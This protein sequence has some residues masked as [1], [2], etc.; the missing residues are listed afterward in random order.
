MKPH[1]YKGKHDGK[2]MCTCGSTGI[3]CEVRL[4]WCAYFSAKHWKNFDTWHQALD[5][6]LARVYQLIT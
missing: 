2:G 4:M 1:I 6:V 3:N 5:Y